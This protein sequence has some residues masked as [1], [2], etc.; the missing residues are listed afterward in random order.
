MISAIDDFE[1]QH[2]ATAAAFPQKVRSIYI[3]GADMLRVYLTDDAGF[4][5]HGYELKLKKLPSGTWVVVD[6]RTFGL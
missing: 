1:K 5:G 6:S 2:P 3:D 4:K